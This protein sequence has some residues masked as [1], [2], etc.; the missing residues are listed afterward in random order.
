MTGI[1]DFDQVLETW[2]RHQ[3]PP[4]A[5]DRVL[6]AA[7]ERVGSAS[8][9]RSWLQRLLGGT[10]MTTMVRTTAAAVVI[11][12][13]AIFGLQL[14]SPTPN[15]G[16]SPMPSRSA[17]PTEAVTPSPPAES[18]AP[19]PS[20]KPSPVASPA[21]IAVRLLGGSD[22]GPYHVI[23]ILADGRLI[24]GD[25]LAATPPMERR[26]TTA[27]IQLVRDEIA[28]TGLTDT[29]ANFE[30]VP[31][32]G[33]EP[34]GFIG[35]LGQLEIA[36]A[37]GNTVVISWNLYGDR[38]HTYFKPQP[39]AEALEALKVRL[40]MLESW[41][42][43]LAWA[44]AGAAPYVPAEYRMTINAAAWGGS[45]DALRDVTALSWPVA[46]DRTDLAEVLASA[47]DETRCRLVDAA[48]GTAVIEALQAAGARRE[49]EPYLRF[50]LGMSEGTRSIE[51]TLAP[52]L[53]FDVGTC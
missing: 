43:A 52:L 28:E 25:P 9:R 41:L 27:G 49:A 3:A 48:A 50:R 13:V 34:P 2:L 40:S 6:D 11:A 30:P 42:P 19:T 21:S 1:N 8:Q 45:V 44:D 46:V 7:L 14:I 12:V 33:I 37:G 26:L 15:V 22:A 23:S 39:E 47:E 24:I 18:A 16:P 51:I 20:A 32:P 4:Q 29:N 17:Q 35:S 5:P 36:Q 38:E 53:P 10:A 31:N